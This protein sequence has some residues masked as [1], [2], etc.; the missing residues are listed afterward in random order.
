[1][2]DGILHSGIVLCLVSLLRES[3]MNVK[4]LPILQTLGNIIAGTTSQAQI[5]IDS[6]ILDVLQPLLRH[7]Q[8]EVRKEA[9]WI[10]GNIV[11]GNKEQVNAMSTEIL[12][13]LASIA[14]YDRWPVRKEA[15]WALA[16]LC[17]QSEKTYSYSCRRGSIE[18]FGRR[19]SYGVS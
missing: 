15:T 2:I 8:L 9:T 18:F 5:I 14:L 6:G 11:A 7:E 13:E 17:E 19:L 3:S 16:T 10:A 1:V 4:T 12:K